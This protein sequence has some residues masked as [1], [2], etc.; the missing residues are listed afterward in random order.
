MDLTID[1]LA[2]RAGAKSSTIRMYQ[3]QGLLPA[4]EIRGRIGYYG[5]GHLARLALIGR[6]QEKGYSLAAIRDLTES[7]QSGRS[8][9]ALLGLESAVGE[10]GPAE[11]IDLTYAEFA[12]RFGGIE[13]EPATIARAVAM[14][15]VEL[16]EDGIHVLDRRFVAI[17][18]EL[19][20]LGLAPA[21]VLEEW[22]HVEQATAAL[23]ERFRT[24]FERT[25]WEPFVAAGMPADR[26]EPVTEALTRLRTLGRDIVGIAM[27]AA[28]AA[29]TDSALAEQAARL[30][31]R[32][33]GGPVPSE[34]AG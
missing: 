7:W 28:I 10:P 12:E 26:I 11:P 34:A 32:A 33:E 17:G 4:P 5:D 15:L 3:H 31:G 9:G 27:D 30:D 22:A 18:A 1:E 8:V 21:D 14:G 13:M 25:V 6:L 16:R 19:V 24:V 23:A 2:A 29:A 20:A